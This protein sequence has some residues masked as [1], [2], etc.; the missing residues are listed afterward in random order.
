MMFSA[1]GLSDDGR[2]RHTLVANGGRPDFA[3]RRNWK[4]RQRIRK[5]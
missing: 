2:S 3:T 1:M 4:P 5:N